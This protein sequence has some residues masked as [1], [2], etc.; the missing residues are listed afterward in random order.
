[1]PSADPPTR[2]HVVTGKGGTGKTTVAAALALAL[3][4]RGRRVLLCEV[5]GRQGIAHRFGVGDL[6]A[7][8]V[9][10]AA[11]LGA[12][13]ASRG[14]RRDGGTVFALHLDPVAALREYLS[15]YARLGPAT[16]LLESFGVV[17]F[18]TSIAPGLRDVLL[19]GKVYEATRTARRG[20]VRTYD[21]VVLDAPPTGRIVRFLSANAEL[22]GL[23][24]VGPIRAQ[25]EG[26]M[27]LLRS[28]E[29]RIH[30]VTILEEMSV[31]ETVEAIAEV[32]EAGLPVGTVIA[33]RTQ[34]PFLDAEQAALARSGGVDLDSLGASLDRVGLAEPGLAAALAATGREHGI[35]RRL[36]DDQLAS[37]RAAGA[38]P[39][40]LPAVATGVE[41]TTLHGFAGTLREALV[42]P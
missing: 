39:V 36:E 18:A 10:I 34:S 38:A 41:F 9:R 20:D 2:L 42:T 8:E 5:E 13:G 27:R 17:E 15:T 24:R 29:T 28:P 37:L 33:N 12:A 7:D 3:A 32:T 26:V 19:T 31:Q 22:A 40:L 35:R 16:R 11:G 25:A 23:A 4:T 6:P 30:L 14:G 21:A 1:M